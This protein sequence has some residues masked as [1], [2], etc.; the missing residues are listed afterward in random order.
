MMFVSVIGMEAAPLDLQHTTEHT[1]MSNHSDCAQTKAAQEEGF[2]LV[3][4]KEDKVIDEQQKGSGGSSSGGNEVGGQAQQKKRKKRAKNWTTE[5]TDVLLS[6]VVSHMQENEGQMDKR[7][8]CSGMLSKGQ[9]EAISQAVHGRTWE[10]CRGRMDTLKKYC[11]AN[12]KKVQE[13]EKD[14]Q[15]MQPKPSP[16]FKEDWYNQIRAH[17]LRRPK[18]R[19]IEVAESV[20][21]LSKIGSGFVSSTLTLGNANSLSCSFALCKI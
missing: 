7:G 5:E 3:G 18:K 14:F 4:N 10:E 1:G 15:A 11:D 19:R 16:C 17:C 12:K 6:Q 2:A 21:S 9:W 20:P 13:L 8:A